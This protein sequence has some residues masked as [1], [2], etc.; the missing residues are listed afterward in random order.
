MGISHSTNNSRGSAM[1]T[2]SNRL[3]VKATELE[4]SPTDMLTK[5]LM[6]KTSD[7]EGL[8]SG[9]SSGTFNKYLFPHY[10][11]LGVKLFNYIA[12]KPNSKITTCSNF[13]REIEKFLSIL[14]DDQQRQIY[15]AMF[16][17]NQS[18][19]NEQFRN[20]LLV[21]YKIAMYHYP[22]GPQSCRQL[23]RT[24]QAVVEGA[25]HRKDELSIGYMKTWTERNTPRLINVLHRYVV[26]ILGTSHVHFR[27]NFSC[28][29]ARSLPS[30]ELELSTPVLE[31][32]CS[33]FWESS[34]HPLLPV[35]QVWILASTLPTLFTKPS[36][37][38]NQT[39]SASLLQATNHIAKF[40]DLN[41]P[42]HWTLLYNSNQ[43]GLGPNRFLHH[44]MNYKG[45]T[46]TFL[47]AE[48]DLEFCIGSTHEW[49]ETQYYWGGEE[50]TIIQILPNYHVLER[51][52][53]SMYLNFTIRGYPHG[54]KAGKDPRAPILSIDESFVLIH[55]CKVPYKLLSIEVWGC[56][57]P[58]ERE[59][60]LDIRKWQVKEAEKQRV[61]KVKSCD[62]GNHPDRYL[63]ELA[64]TPSSNF[65]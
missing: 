5:A 31:K 7:E 19:S 38:L 64:R 41:Y 56:G 43:H 53:K 24:V 44:V 34:A 63:L 32:D 10:P 11:E 25:Y 37:E 30:L 28:P 6:Q 42:S 51:G 61:V 29:R 17:D 59:V 50:C 12:G 40:L 39:H 20:L 2:T 57:T 62:W 18:I 8:P 22:E 1:K 13:K 26:H 14:S 15:L 47:R 45:P 49:H 48:Q 58:K 52:A 55:F 23:F 35:S 65:G 3:Q 54:I 36:H 60:Q 21:I 9:I 16:G 4:L 27:D 33:H 46:L